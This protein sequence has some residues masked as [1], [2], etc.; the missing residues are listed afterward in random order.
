MTSQSD[1]DEILTRLRD[2][3]DRLASIGSPVGALEPGN[4]L[5]D[6]AE[7]GEELLVAEEELR[8]QHE[9]LVAVRLEMERVLARTTELF[10][11]S[12]TAHVITDQQG[13]IVDATAAAWQLFDTIPRSARRPIVSMFATPHRRCIRSLISAVEQGAGGQHA[14][15]VLA[16]HGRWVRVAVERRTE[17]QSGTSLLHWHLTPSRDGESKPLPRPVDAEPPAASTAPGADTA[18]DGELSRLLSLARSDLAAELSA[19]QS[20]DFFLRRLVQLT[21]RRIPGTEHASVTQQHDDERLRF[22][23]ATDSVAM[24]CDRLQFHHAQGPAFDAPA[25]A[26]TIRVDDLRDDHRWPAFGPG[27]V[28][29][30]IRSVLACELPVSGQNHATLNLYSGEPSAFKPMAELVA[31]VF[32]ARASI[33]LSHVDEVYN[34]R[35]AIAS[36]QTIGQAVGILVER[37]RITADEAFDRLV[38]ASKTSHIKL[39]DLARIVAETGEEPD[40]AR[41]R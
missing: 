11:A 22:A 30:G 27:A 25:T 4:S 39:R 13:M 21:V 36:R 40:Q 12:S 32:A 19:E 6:V 34:L 10:G 8:V 17:P 18:T 1:L 26:G 38:A 23:A 9:E 20:P 35:R 7:L 29:L 37:H 31:P 14:E 2:Y 41:R 3:R 16:R 33:A 5:L 24:A 15:A 28:D